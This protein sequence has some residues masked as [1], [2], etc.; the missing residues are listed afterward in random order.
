MQNGFGGY[1]VQARGQ[2]LHARSEALPVMAQ[3]QEQKSAGYLRVRDG[4]EG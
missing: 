3:D 2:P 1:R 4:M